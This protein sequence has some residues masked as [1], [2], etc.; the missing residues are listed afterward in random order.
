MRYS[1]DAK[2]DATTKKKRQYYAM[3]GTRGIWENGWKASAVH[4]PLPARATSTR[5]EWELYHVDA[6]RSEST[7]LAKEASGEAQGADQAPGSRRRRRTR[8][9][10]STTAARWRCSHERPEEGRRERYIYYPGTSP[11]PEGVAVNVRGR[12][13]KILADVEITDP[14]CSGV[15]FAH[16]SRFGGHALFIKDKKL[17]YVYNFLGIK[18][19]QSSSRHQLKPGKYTLGVEFIREE[20]GKYDESLGKTRL[21]VNEKVVAEGEMR[22]PARQVHA[23]G[24]WPLHRAR[25]RRRRQRGYKAPGVLTGGAIRASNQRGEGAV[26]RPQNLGGGG[27]RG[28]VDS[29]YSRRR[30]TQTH[31][32]RHSASDC[33]H[34]WARRTPP[35]SEGISWIVMSTRFRCRPPNRFGRSRRSFMTTAGRRSPVSVELLA[36]YSGQPLTMPASARRPDRVHLCA[37]APRLPASRSGR[38]R[39]PRSVWCGPRPCSGRCC[40]SVGSL[41]LLSATWRGIWGATGE[42]PLVMIVAFVAIGLVVGRFLGGPDPRQATVLALSTA[43]RHP[44]ITL[45]IASA[46]FPDEP[47]GATVV[48]VPARRAGVAGAGRHVEPGTYRR[49]W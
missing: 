44:A 24:R 16:G 35:C 14:N 9:C 23:V 12:S 42:G 39:L 22:D 32:D 11:V 34:A 31:R 10:R 38:G 40:W 26:P 29:R 2:P 28:R 19:E 48:L 43:C 3:L 46:N 30:R 15:I 25:Q 27:V 41:L 20:H 6:D 47:F 37:P 33:G 7:D 13:Y 49:C 4:A 8:C 21:Y 17:Y 36:A 45:S 5:T 18:P 1:F